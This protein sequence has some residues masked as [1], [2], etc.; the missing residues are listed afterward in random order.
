MKT[1]ITET[2]VDSETHTLYYMDTEGYT[3]P[4][5]QVVKGMSPVQYDTDHNFMQVDGQSN[6]DC[7]SLPNLNDAFAEFGDVDINL[8]PQEV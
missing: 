2:V 3:G 6:I 8:T 5:T 7:G 4:M 1:P